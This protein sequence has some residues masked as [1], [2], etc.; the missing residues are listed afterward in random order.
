MQTTNELNLL[1]LLVQG[2]MVM[3]PILFLSIAAC[4]LIIERWMSIR[5]KTSRNHLLLSQVT[6]QLHN[7]KLQ[8][9]LLLCERDNSACAQVLYTGLQNMGKPITEMEHMMESA[10]QIQIAEMEHKLNYLGLIAG[11]AP[12]LGFI[13]TISGVIR[14]FYNIAISDNFTISTIA[15]GLYEKMITSGAGLVVGVL[16][17]TGYHLLNMYMDT[18]VAGIQKQSFLFIQTLQRPAYEDSKK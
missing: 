17:Y 18:I 9:A 14:I 8:S 15:S 3:I 6:D 4:Y 1:T 13:G 12:M 2:G 5:N 7:G 10:A 16:A 11:I